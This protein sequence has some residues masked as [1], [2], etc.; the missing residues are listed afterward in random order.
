MNRIISREKKVRETV[1]VEING[2]D[3]KRIS[4]QYS[5]DESD[6]QWF[7]LDIFSDLFNLDDNRERDQELED[8]YIRLLREEKLNRII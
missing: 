1:E 7:D 5:N 4:T 8:A 3:Y 6:V 2:K